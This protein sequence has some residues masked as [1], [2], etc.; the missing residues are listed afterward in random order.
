MFHPVHY[1]AIELF[2]NR[3]VRHRR[4]RSSPMPM[5]LAR[6]EP[7]H[8]AW[9]NLLHRSALALDPAAS[10]CYDERL[11]QWVRM[12]GCPG[13]RL[14]SHAGPGDQRWIR[15]LKQWI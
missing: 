13:T 2:L 12:P 10:R 1:L 4:R 7:D 8:V 9:S 3:D 14:E 15:R 5:F 11:T 6:C